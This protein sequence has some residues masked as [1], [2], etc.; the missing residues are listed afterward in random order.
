MPV[1]EFTSENLPTSEE[2]RRML[3]LNDA[4]YDPLEELL[5]L[6]RDL[7]KLE[8]THGLSS[9]EFYTQYQAGK[10]GD[11]R[12]FICWAGRYTL[13]LRLKAKISKSLERIMTAETVLF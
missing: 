2:F 12:E 6:E 10:F 3:S 8:Q 4:T 1:L 5:R 7:A 9:A 11:D 13:Y